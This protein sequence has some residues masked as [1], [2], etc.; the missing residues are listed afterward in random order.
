MAQRNRVVVLGIDNFSHKNRYQ[1]EQLNQEGYRFDFETMDSRGDSLANFHGLEKAGNVLWLAPRG[2]RGLFARLQHAAR[3]LMRRDVHHAEVYPGGRFAFIYA[4]LVRLAGRRLLVVERGDLVNWERK[5]LL[6][7]LSMRICY[8]L[9]S[10]VW[11]REPYMRT[12]LDAFGVERAEFIHNAVPLGQVDARLPT[13]EIDFLWA[14][15]LV[16]QRRPDWFVDVLATQA[17]A[18][19]QNALLGMEEGVVDPFVNE[20]QRYVREHCP[21]NLRL[22]GFVPPTTFY[23]RAR[24]F[25]LPATVVFCNHALL[26]A[27]AHGVIPIVSASNGTELIVE[28]GVNGF[29]ADHTPDG[30]RDAMHR[31][32][33]LSK[34]EWQVM[35]TRARATADERFGSRVWRERMQV[36]YQTL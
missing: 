22:H 15:R 8:G 3:V 10:A 30:L 12:Y 21:A 11:Y 18:D 4:L 13:P 7:R 1:I 20:R 31:A 17:F 16:E 26:E 34:D 25:V 9:A 35:S 23:R 24:F 33:R 19:T 29:V 14:N 28:D 27:M 2:L 32:L 36:L 5:G 6:A